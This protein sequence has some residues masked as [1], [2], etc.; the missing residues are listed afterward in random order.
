MDV[1][2]HM[3]VNAG[4]HST[5]LNASTGLGHQNN[6]Q[7]TGPAIRWLDPLLREQKQSPEYRGGENDRRYRMRTNSCCSFAFLVL[8]Y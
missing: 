3:S 6:E 4:M 2:G 8:F 5:R 1:S 7:N